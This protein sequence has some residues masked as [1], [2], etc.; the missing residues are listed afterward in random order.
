MSL[1]YQTFQICYTY[2]NFHVIFSFIINSVLY[3]NDSV[4]FLFQSTEGVCVNTIQTSGRVYALVIDPDNNLIIAGVG[5][6]IK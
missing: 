1:Q 6:S 4:C 2:I 3:T 5:E